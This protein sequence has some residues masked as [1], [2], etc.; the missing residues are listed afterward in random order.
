MAGWPGPWPG[1]LGLSASTLARSC[2]QVSGASWRI[3]RWRPGWAADG[4][5]NCRSNVR[6]AGPRPVPPGRRGCDSA[7]GCVRHA[8]AKDVCRPIMF[9]RAAGRRQNQA[10]LPLVPDVIGRQCPGTDRRGCEAVRP[11]CEH[12]PADSRR[13]CEG[14]QPAQSPD[15]G[16]AGARARPAKHRNPEAASPRPG[17]SAGPRHRPNDRPRPVPAARTRNALAASPGARPPRRSP[18]RAPSWP[19]PS[20]AP[21]QATRTGCAGCARQTRPRRL[22]SS[23]SAATGRSG[24]SAWGP[25]PGHDD[26]ARMLSSVPS[27]YAGASYGRR[28]SPAR[29]AASGRKRGA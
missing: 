16:P 10:G 20:G 24:R 1:Q 18:S 4:R 7:A 8:I 25:P 26:R 14:A 17:S 15:A 6:P 22:R 13:P 19:G 5:P 29:P 23:C 3:R 12:P 21:P 11:E 27:G 28:S 9:P 2:C